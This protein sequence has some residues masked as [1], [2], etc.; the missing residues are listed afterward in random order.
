MPLNIHPLI[1]HTPV[2]LLSLYSFLEI[3]SIKRLQSLPYWFYVKAIL[4]IFG[5][6]GTFAALGSGKLIED[7]FASRLLETHAWF[8]VATT[9][10]YLVLAASYLLTWF[11]WEIN[12]YLE[13]TYFKQIWLLFDKLREFIMKRSILFCLSG[14]GFV[15]LSIT[16]ALGGA[17]AYGPDVDPMVRFIYDLFFGDKK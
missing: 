4:V 12:K 5:S 8:A 9:L 3:I 11:R 13:K 15:F 2:G 1:V 14:L 7:Q 10:V 16:G 17:L 6:L